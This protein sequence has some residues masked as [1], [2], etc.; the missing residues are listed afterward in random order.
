MKIDGKK[1]KLLRY[2]SGLTMEEVA[3]SA[4]LSAATIYKLEEGTTL[5]HPRTT[6]KICDALGK[7][8]D[9]LFELVDDKG[10]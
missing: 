10:K 3:K 7:D 9:E 2:K 6:K 5:C 8:F 4:K 1:L